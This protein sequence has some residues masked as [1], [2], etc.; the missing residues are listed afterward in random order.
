MNEI[1]VRSIDV[2]TDGGERKYS[3]MSLS[4]YHCDH[5]KSHVNHLRI[6]PDLRDFI[7]L[8]KQECEREIE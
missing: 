1:N 4:Q 8:Q 3:E 5:H 6:K 7:Q 2:I